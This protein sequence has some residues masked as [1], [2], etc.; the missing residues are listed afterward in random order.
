MDSV[1]SRKNK[2]FLFYFSEV[3]SKRIL[4]K[5]Y[6]L[7]HIL[8]LATVSDKMPLTLLQS[9]LT[10]AYFHVLQAASITE[11]GKLDLG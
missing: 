2:L 8:P 7:D 4:F 9:T 10:L 11:N 1:L 6:M 3:F 5:M